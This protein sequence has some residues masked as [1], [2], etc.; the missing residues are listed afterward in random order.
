MFV[1]SETVLEARKD[2][3]KKRDMDYAIMKALD[4][5]SPSTIWE[6]F[7]KNSIMLTTAACVKTIAGF[8]NIDKEE[9]LEEIEAP[10]SEPVNQ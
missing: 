4:V 6:W 10:I 9:V 2:K 7:R 3:D 5:A 8:L 1:I